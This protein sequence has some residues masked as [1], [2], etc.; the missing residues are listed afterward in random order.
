MPAEAADEDGAAQGVRRRVSPPRAVSAGQG[1]CGGG[2]G[3]RGH[4]V[5][6]GLDPA[7]PLAD[8]QCPSGRDA[9]AKPAHDGVQ[10]L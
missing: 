10:N 8:A 7:I 9:R 4:W 2:A 3:R 5:M 6:A 1:C